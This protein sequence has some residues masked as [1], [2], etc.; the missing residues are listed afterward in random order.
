MK[1]KSL[2]CQTVMNSIEIANIPISLFSVRTLHETIKQAITQSNKKVYLYANAYLV[3]LAN[4]KYP[5]LVNFFNSMDY[6]IC[7][8][9]SIQLGAK[10]IGQEIPEKIPYNIWF[11]S[12][13]DFLSQNGFSIYLLGADEKTILRAA[14]QAQNKQPNLKLKGFHH[15]YFNKTKEHSDNR[16]VLKQIDEAKPDVLLVG[17]GMPIQELWIKENLSRINA[18]AIFSCGGAFDFISGNKPTAPKFLRNL[19]LEWLYRAFLEPKRLLFRNLSSNF[20]LILHL[21]RY[22]KNQK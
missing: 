10:I 6:V 13:I 21:A 12:L 8:G 9:A 5:W 11:W 3:K 20:Y 7:D 14:R 18:K 17:F 1:G 15:G 22:W 2:L 16:L 19:Y 4:T